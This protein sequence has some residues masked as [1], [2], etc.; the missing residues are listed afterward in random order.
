MKKL[1]WLVIEGHPGDIRVFLKLDDSGNVSNKGLH[2]K[3]QINS[4]EKVTSN[5]N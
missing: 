5:G 1:R 2:R 4:A 3:K